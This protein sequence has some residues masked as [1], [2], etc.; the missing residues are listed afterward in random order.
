[1]KKIDVIV[2]WL[3]LCCSIKSFCQQKLF[4][5]QQ[6]KLPNGWKLT[7]V[8]KS[9]PLGDLPLNIVISS[10]K[11]YIAVTNN[12]QSIQSIQLI[13]AM[14]D[15]ILDSIDI[16]ESWLGLKFTVDEKF[17]YAS[18]GNLNRILKY[19]IVNNKLHLTDSIVLGNPWPVK[20]SPTG[21]D[22]DDARQIMYVVTKENNSLYVVNLK[23]KTIIQKDTLGAEAYTCLL[24]PDKKELYIS[25]WGGDKIKIFNTNTKTFSDSVAVGDNPNDMCLSKNGQWLYVANA[26]DNSVS[27]INIQQRKVLETLNA[28]LYPD[29]RQG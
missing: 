15:K 11:K 16:A 25:V 10:T 26:N 8:G 9:L 13:D 21:I 3:L 20:I 19:A 12:G 22:I 28:A 29:S 18:E 5:P 23:T 4:L 6:I 7:P 14:H 17:L 1:M 2:M 27:V 24:S